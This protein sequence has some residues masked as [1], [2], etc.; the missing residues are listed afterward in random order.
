ME[1]RE[2]V[3]GIDLGTTNSAIS[4]VRSGKMSEIIPLKEGRKTMPSCVMWLGGD[5]FVVGME[6][7]QHRYQENVVYS[8]KSHMED[9]DYKVKLQYEG[10]ELI[11]TPAQVSAKI[12]EGLIAETGG[13]YGTIRKVVVTVPAYFNINGVEATME[14]CQLAGLEVVS[15]IR[16]PTAA[17]ACYDLGSHVTNREVLVYDLGGGTFDISLVRIGKNVD[18]LSGFYG[19]SDG[20]DEKKDEDKTLTVIANNGDTKLGGDDIDR[21]L[22]KIVEQR[23]AER[24]VKVELISIE[25]REKMILR[26]D[27]LKKSGVTSIYEVRFNSTL[28]DGTPVDETIRVMPKD[29]ADSLRPIY[30]KTKKL[31]DSVIQESGTKANTLVLVGGST[32]N[33]IL[34]ELLA[35]DYPGFT[36]EDA[37]DPDQ[38]VSLGAA[39]YG[40][41]LVYGDADIQVFDIIPMTVGVLES[42][43]ISPLIRKNSMLPVSASKLF[44][45]VVDN[46]KSVQVDL[47]QG[48]STIPDECV[49]LGTI[50]IDGIKP[51][52][53]KVPVLQVSITVNRDSILS[54]YAVI[55]G[56]EKEIKLSLSGDKSVKKLDKE[57]QRKK[58]WERLALTRG[59]EFGKKLMSLLEGYPQFVTKE[60]IVDFIQA[61]GGQV[62]RC[63]GK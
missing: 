61:E 22:Y 18:T 17:S 54:C 3:F 32:K 30:R 13:V 51:A 12:L 53:A 40:Q 42:G 37:L 43:R 56:M 44:T 62:E 50:I 4:V 24:G 16:E 10:E 2:P 58:R 1:K 29:F 19:F 26:M 11:L 47:Y 59:G 60:M 39:I 57:E 25:D 23:L 28:E 55:D 14:A 6:A 63:A 21:E 27:K 34:K 46:Q 49:C 20:T 33:V 31:V 36:I 45:T 15:I 52:P 5:Q 41:Q 7:Y 35:R 9:R 8:V 48:N 38:S